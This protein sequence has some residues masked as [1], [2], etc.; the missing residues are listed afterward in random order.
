MICKLR[1]QVARRG[2]YRQCPYSSKMNRIY[3]RSPMQ[4]EKF[5]PEGTWIMPDTRFS[6]FPALSLTRGKGFLGLHRRPMFDYFP[7]L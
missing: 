3:H 1:I 4:T 6:E 5:Q 7:C 2:T